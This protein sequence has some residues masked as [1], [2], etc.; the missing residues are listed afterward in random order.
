MADLI[1]G[2]SSYERKRGDFPELPVT[3]MLAENVPTEPGTAL[4]SRP[5]LTDTVI[6]MGSGPVR[7][8]FRADGVLYNTLF[9][10][11]G[12]DLYRWG[13]YIGTTDGSGPVSFAAYETNIFVNAGASIWGW[14]G[15]TYSSIPFPDDANVAKITTGASRL[16]AIRKDTGQFYWSDV[17]GS[18][19]NALNFATA[20]KLPDRLKDML[21]I[22]DRLYLFG[23]ESVEIWPATTDP[24][25]PFAPLAGAVM[26]VGVKET[27]LAVQFGTSFAWITNHN[28]VCVGSPDNIISEP[29]LQVRIKESMEHSLWT[30][31][32]DDNEFLVVRLEDETWVYGARSGVWSKF[33][34]HGEDNWLPLTYDEQYFGLSNT[35]NLARWSTAYNDFGGPIERSTRAWIPITAESVLLSNV[36]MRT[37]PGTTPYIEG[38][39]SEPVVELRTSRDGGK[40]WQPWKQ[41]SMGPVGNYRRKIFWSSLG[42]FGYPGVM[43]EIRNSDPVPFRISGLAYNEPFGGR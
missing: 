18:D 33:T 23:S 27:G 39:Y 7:K 14:D 1:Y 38:T 22:G 31:F 4:Q 29:E 17:L 13:T 41:R 9:G 16:V 24:D 36:I 43:V 35:G 10:L 21:Y 20:E 6:T 19:I 40:L 37:N 3:N 2:V 32:V 5:G 25:L 12:N 11:S 8:L 34:S 42:M 15:T 28:E 26:P 30:F